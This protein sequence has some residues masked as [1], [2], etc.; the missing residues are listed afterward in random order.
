MFLFQDG[1]LKFSARYTAHLVYRN[2]RPYQPTAKPAFT[3][4]S[5]VGRNEA[6]GRWL[7]IHQMT[8]QQFTDL[9]CGPQKSSD[10]GGLPL[11]PTGLQSDFDGP[12]PASADSS[13]WAK[14]MEDKYREFIG[15]IDVPNTQVKIG[16]RFTDIEIKDFNWR[17]P[18]TSSSKRENFLNL[19]LD[20]LVSDSHP[21]LFIT[22]LPPIIYHQV[23]NTSSSPFQLPT[24]MKCLTSFS[25][26][27]IVSFPCTFVYCQHQ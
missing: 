22:I 27:T 17:F 10:I 24:S 20:V 21:H 12:A 11:N 16:V 13:S 15:S 23:P 26:L 8:V 1:R 14:A 19:S 3:V 9:V 25:Y 18:M 2:S 6:L 4:K 5:E 7:N